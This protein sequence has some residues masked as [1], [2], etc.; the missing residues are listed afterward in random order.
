MTKKLR[1]L[2][3]TSTT[4]LLWLAPWSALAAE[5]E[6]KA[7]D[8]DDATNCIEYLMK[9]TPAPFTGMLAGPR[10]AALLTVRSSMCQVRVSEARDE[11]KEAGDQKLAFEQLGRKSD[12]A[13]SQQKILLMKKGME[14]YETQFGPKWSDSAFQGSG[15]RPRSRGA[16]RIVGQPADRPQRLGSQLGT[17]RLPRGRLRFSLRDERARVKRSYLAN[18]SIGTAP[19]C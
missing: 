7:C 9:G 17:P 16:W 3:A 15:H 8:P 14:A 18:R 6:A 11:E 19:K 2:I 4:L 12:N 5:P 1:L 10:R 13:A